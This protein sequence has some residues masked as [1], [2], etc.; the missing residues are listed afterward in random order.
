MALDPLPTQVQDA[1]FLAAHRHPALFSEP[2][3]GKTITALEGWKRVGGRLCVVAPPIALRM[4]QRNISEHLDARAQVITSGKD[5]IDHT[6]DAHVL[7]YQMV[8]KF[9]ALKGANVLVLDES[10]A[11]KSLNSQRTSAVFGRAAHMKDCLAEGVEHVWPLTGTPIRRYADDLYPHL[12]ALHPDALRKAFG[13]WTYQQFVSRFCTTQL[14]RFHAR[15]RAQSTVIGNKNEAELRGL[16]YGNNLAVRRTI[17]DVAA[18]MPPLTLREVSVKFDDTAELREATGEALGAGEMEPVMA[19]ARRLLGTAKAPHVA[20]YVVDVW[21]Q[22]SCAVLLFYWHKEAGDILEA[23]LREA[24]LIVRRIDGATSAEK[25]AEYE[26]AFN[27]GDIDILLGQIASMGVAIN[28]QQGSHYG[29]FAEMDWSPA[30]KDQA[31]RRLW[32]LGQQTH[33]QIDVCQADHPLDE[34][35]SMVLDR[36]DTSAKKV[37]D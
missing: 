33:V 25:R 26:R 7:S 11:L 3:T 16:I 17:H 2:G 22:L 5:V 8:G 13:I 20:E 31:L 34:A 28:L 10:D 15:Q 9:Q 36:K 12:R 6:A 29:V 14:R 27:A 1:E 37:V 30:A 21:E 23:R 32:R 18:F 4:W 19:T 35:V 24:G